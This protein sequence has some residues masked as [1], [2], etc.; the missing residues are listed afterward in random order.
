MYLART[1]MLWYWS[2]IYSGNETFKG[3]TNQIAPLAL[4]VGV[5]YKLAQFHIT[6]W[7]ERAD[8]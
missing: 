2:G 1:Q 5:V 4:A 3:L 8:I 6:K 7:P